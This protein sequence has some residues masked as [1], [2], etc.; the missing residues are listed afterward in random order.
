[1]VALSARVA[2]P[3]VSVS[4]LNGSDSGTR[5]AVE[6]CGIS[7]APSCRAA[8]LAGS[9]TERAPP[10]VETVL[11]GAAAMINGSAI[12]TTSAPRSAMILWE[13]L[14]VV[15]LVRFESLALR[16]CR[17]FYDEIET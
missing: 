2:P 4:A 9:S 12:P 10:Y 5:V 11:P 6:G 17:L 7:G 14:C 3:T 8:R 13:I 1:V 15:K 16:F